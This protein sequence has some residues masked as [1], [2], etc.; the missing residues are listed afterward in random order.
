MAVTL[1]KEEAS[2]VVV[3]ELNPTIFTPYWFVNNGLLDKQSADSANVEII[4]RDICIFQTSDFHLQV[5]QNR[6]IIRSLGPTPVVIYDLVNR[7]FGE[8]LIHTNLDAAGINYQAS[9][10]FRDE[11]SLHDLGDR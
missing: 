1:V 8:F 7:T 5:E 3:G 6:L 4:H 9:F 10:R 2:I 11:K